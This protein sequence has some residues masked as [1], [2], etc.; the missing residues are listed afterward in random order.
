MD[1]TIN[2]FKFIN[3]INRAG[4]ISVSISL[5]L[6]V[7]G[8]HFL[9]ALGL[10]E[11]EAF[12][13]VGLIEL[14]ILNT[15][16]IK[17]PG[18]TK[19]SVKVL[20]LLISVSLPV[21]GE[22]LKY[23]ELND[24]LIKVKVSITKPIEKSV[25]SIKLRIESNKSELSELKQDIEKYSLIGSNPVGIYRTGKLKGKNYTGSDVAAWRRYRA[26]KIQKEIIKLNEQVE[27]TLTANARAIS[28]YQGAVTDVKLKTAGLSNQVKRQVYLGGF[29]AFVFVCLGLV[30]M[31]YSHA[32]DDQEESVST[33]S[34]EA[35]IKKLH[36]RQAKR[37][38]KIIQPQ[39]GINF[40]IIREM[41]KFGRNRPGLKVAA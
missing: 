39:P 41:V 2:S 36:K 10:A 8:F 38:D 29:M 26:K 13:M 16:R 5:Y 25:E 24:Q 20:F 18:A 33:V 4:L 17:I 32:S 30:N 21:A 3:N 34:V 12:V 23:S 9:K 22:Y 14:I 27:S 35:K 28:E 7:H 19:W 15:S 31:V 40:N 11:W 37:L 1:K 6:G